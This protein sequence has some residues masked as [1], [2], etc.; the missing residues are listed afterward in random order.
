[1]GQGQVDAD[2]AV[3]QVAAELE[4]ASVGKLR[5]QLLT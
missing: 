2:L 3:Q 4:L 5:E 1:M